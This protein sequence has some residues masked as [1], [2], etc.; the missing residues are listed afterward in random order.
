M[1]FFEVKNIVK[2]FGGLRAVNDISFTMEQGEILGLIGPNGS[3]KT[4]IFNLING[5]YPLTSGEIYFKGRRID[6]LPPHKICA[7]G[8]GRTFQ[9]VKPLK[10]MS[11]LDNVMVGAFLRTSS[12]A[13]ARARAL[14]VLEFCGLYHRRDMDARNLT[15]A[16]RKRLEI[17]RALATEP[18]LLLLD[19]TAAGLNPKETEEAIEIILKIKRAGITIIIVEHIMKV[20]M[21]ISDR[22]LAISFGR[23]IAIGTPKEIVNHPEVIKA[24]LGEAYA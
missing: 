14:D 17:A 16:D 19:E 5:F 24:Y 3:G 8:I 13:M 23:E 18:Q 6:G 10:R 7:L 22:I 1:S 21:G 12:I 11:V 9:V 20:I 2:N 4:T 15:I